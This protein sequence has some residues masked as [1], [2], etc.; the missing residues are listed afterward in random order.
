VGPG[1]TAGET[2]DVVIE[3][4]RGHHLGRAIWNGQAAE[5]TG[6]PG[7]VSGHAVDRV[8]RAPA[9]GRLT[10]QVVLGAMLKKDDCIATFDELEVR[11]PFDGV[12]RGLIHESVEVSQGEKIGDVDP[13]LDPRGTGQEGVGARY[14]NDQD[15]GASKRS[16]RFPHR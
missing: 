2:C 1:F 3:T 9:D 13:R 5:D 12:L 8:L 6:V 10:P 14:H 7:E 16:G 15:L 11:A 4:K